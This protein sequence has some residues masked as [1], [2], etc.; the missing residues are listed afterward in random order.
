MENW[1]GAERGVAVRAFY[2]NGDSAT[3]RIEHFDSITSL[4]VMDVSHL[5]MRLQRG[6]V[7]L[8]KQDLP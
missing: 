4:D 1:T 6:C 8:K 7:I 3:A 2:K 5:R